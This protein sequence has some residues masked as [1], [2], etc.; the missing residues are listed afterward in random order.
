MR[1]TEDD[2]CKSLCGSLATRKPTVALNSL[3]LT[4]S[5]IISDCAEGFGGCRKASKSPG[6]PG[7]TSFAV[8]GGCAGARAL[9]RLRR[10]GSWQGLACRCG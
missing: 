3:A 1:R 10:G 4:R 2:I 6:W 8:G 7:P 5:I 9:Q